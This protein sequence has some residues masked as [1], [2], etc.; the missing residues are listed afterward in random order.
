MKF[1]FNTKTYILLCIILLNIGYVGYQVAYGSKSPNKTT[2]VKANKEFKIEPN[3]KK[4]TFELLP[5]TKDPFL[6]TLKRKKGTVIKNKNTKEKIS[7]PSIAYSGIVASNQ[8]TSKIFILN[9]NGQ[10]VLLT[11]GEIFQDIKVISGTS[12]YIRVL[13]KGKTK[14]IE[15]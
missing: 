15:M 3:T 1:Q 14:N 5:I 6:G 13:Y 2:A 8:N 11:T 12:A 9:V 10:Q 4:E 7:W